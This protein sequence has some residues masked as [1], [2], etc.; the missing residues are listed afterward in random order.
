MSFPKPGSS[1]RIESYKHDRSFHR[2]WDKTTVV[3][4]SDSV[5][6]GGN[7]NVLVTES[8]GREW[9]TREPALCTFGRGQWFNTIA[10]IREDGTYYY[11]NIGSPFTLKKGVLT[12]IDYDLDIKVFP[13]LTYTLL[14]EEE[15]AENCRSMKYPKRIVRKIKE[16]VNE[17]IAWIEGKKGPFQPGFV[18]RWYERYLVLRD[19][20]T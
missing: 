17:L 15:F 20:G 14:D 2:S 10:M 5:L 19:N 6:I 1:I 12:Y 9:R 7:D 13:D 18:N 11:C 4:V 16:G 8:D 3:H